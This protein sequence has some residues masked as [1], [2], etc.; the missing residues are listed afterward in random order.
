[1]KV[2]NVKAQTN[3]EHM[4]T[5]QT[6]QWQTVDTRFVLNSQIKK[7]NSTLSTDLFGNFHHNKKEQL[8]FCVHVSLI[9]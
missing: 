7:N 1:M 4:E 9:V 2:D 5:V 8:W 6:F 3:M